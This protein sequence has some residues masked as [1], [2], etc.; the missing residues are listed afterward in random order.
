ME[1]ALQYDFIEVGVGPACCGCVENLLAFSVPH[2][3]DF[4]F[5]FHTVELLEF[6]LKIPGARIGLEYVRARKR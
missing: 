1:Q 5:L 4:M 3:M 2:I 6:A